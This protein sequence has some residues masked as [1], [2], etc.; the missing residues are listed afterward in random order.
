MTLKP[1]ERASIELP[2]R[3][4]PKANFEWLKAVCGTRTRPKYDKTTRQF[5]VARVHAKHVLD[6][7]VAEYESVLVTQY[8]H[9]ATTCVEQCWNAR[10]ETVIDCECGCAGHNHGSG[11]PLGKELAAGLSVE[12]ELNRALYVVSAAGWEL[13]P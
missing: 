3:G 9:V 2:W 13:M 12:H 4:G 7:L 6:A 1:G 11:H 8:G 10:R 5:L